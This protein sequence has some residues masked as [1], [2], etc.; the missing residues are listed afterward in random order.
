[1]TLL[2]DRHAGATPAPRISIRKYLLSRLLCLILPI[3]AIGVTVHWSIEGRLLRTLFDES[4]AD[5]TKSLASLI[6][7]HPD[8]IRFN[9]ADEFM[10]EYSRE[11]D[12]Y[13]FQIWRPDGS[14][15]ERSVSL[16]GDD[17][18]RNLGR[19]DAPRSFS[20]TLESGREIR[21]VGIRFPIRQGAELDAPG[22][23][24]VGIVLGVD[25]A[26]LNAMLAQGRFEVGLTGLISAL[27]ISLVVFLALR[28]GARLLQRV[29][30]AVAD[31][32]PGLIAHSG[33]DGDVPEEIRPI[34]RS[35]DESMERIRRFI[36]RE[37]RFNAN[38]AHELRTPIAE[39]RAAAEVALQ[40]PDSDAAEHLAEDARNISVQ[41][42][43]L[44]ESLLELARLEGEGEPVSA[45]ASFDLAASIRLVVERTTNAAA[46]DRVVTLNL[47][48]RLDIVSVRSLWE[49]IA[50]N[51]IENAVEYSPADG[52]VIVSLE[53]AGD[54]A[55]LRIDNFTA[56]LD[57][58]LLE[59]CGERL[60]RNAAEDRSE[61]HFGLGLSIVDAACQRI[62]HEF[63]CA[64]DG[65]R[66]IASVR[67]ARRGR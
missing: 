6:T 50:R 21:C 2:R 38:V 27:G 49:V 55:H 66:F 28:R 36:E 20:T 59:R 64:L 5:K 63:E 18:P 52:E 42:G 25:A 15:L 30:S 67:H 7:E 10:P 4:L 61:R 37:Q 57:A 31:V 17:L 60:W 40:W 41:M 54:G 56:K 47:P 33:A 62:D 45:P 35:L 26:D 39:L 19:I 11:E 46:G 32:G 13:Y 3:V 9:F 51:L 29:S 23:G 65:Q 14:V 34:V 1:M 12:P 44:I 16:R 53:R 8:S 48:E 58:K 22:A 24:S 43:T